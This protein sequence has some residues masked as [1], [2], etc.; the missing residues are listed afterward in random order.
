MLKT[1]PALHSEA[2]PNRIWKIRACI[3][4]LEL[5]R[6]TAPT[7]SWHAAITMLFSM[8][9]ANQMPTERLRVLGTE[10]WQEK[11]KDR[12]LVEKEYPW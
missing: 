9:E 12:I 2:G 7:D 8:F 1:P 5:K 4:I 10:E 3:L 6:S 11:C